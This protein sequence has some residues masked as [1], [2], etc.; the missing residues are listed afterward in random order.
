MKENISIEKIDYLSSCLSESLIKTLE[1]RNG[2]K[3]F[4]G[5]EEKIFILYILRYINDGYINFNK[6]VTSSYKNGGLRTFYDIYSNAIKNRQNFIKEIYKLTQIK[7]LLHF[8]SIFNILFASTIVTFDQAPYCKKNV[9]LNLSSY[10]LRFI[11][12]SKKLRDEF[13]KNLKEVGLNEELAK[14]FS[15][16][17]PR[18]HLEGFKFFRNISYKC[19]EKKII[20]SSIYSL[21]KDPIV[22]FLSMS[23]NTR[24]NYI[25]HGGGYGFNEDRIDYKIEYAGAS[26][27][28]FW[29]SG[30]QNVFQTRFRYK[31]F[32]NSTN[33]I[34]VITSLRFT[35]EEKI[36][37]YANVFKKL[38]DY[39]ESNNF[40]ICLYPSFK[41]SI[42]FKDINTSF[43]ITNRAHEQNKIVIYDSIGSTLLYS[44]LS[45]KKPFLVIDNF[46]VKY[47]SDNAKKMINLFYDSNVLIKEDQLYEEL[48]KLVELDKYELDYVFKK[49]TKKLLDY[50]HSLPKIETLIDNELKDFE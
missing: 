50:F 12:P 39:S 15:W 13:L 45:M 46:P 47:K 5:N 2:S 3:V 40:K 31:N 23:K 21:Q 9:A 4:G 35:S 16:H 22:S 18:S 29:G 1:L 7:L 48:K 33:T 6:E 28:L 11:R 49:R 27:M 42:K 19:S 34:S 30:D 43:G 24:L 26:N 37:K 32:L 17:F 8:K 41:S 25:Q 10:F 44:R 38:E 36:K 14:I 20:Y